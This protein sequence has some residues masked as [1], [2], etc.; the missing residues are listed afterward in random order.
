MVV[1][2]CARTPEASGRTCRTRSNQRR[3]IKMWSSAGAQRRRSG[4]PR[5]QAPAEL[6]DGKEGQ[7]GEPVPHPATVADWVPF[8][9]ARSY[10]RWL[11]AHGIDYL[12]LEE[13]GELER[14]LR[15]EWLHRKGGEVD[16]LR[17]EWLRR[18]NRSPGS[19]RGE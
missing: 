7:V 14:R 9:L 19:T 11:R 12:D 18:E 6:A 8:E 10:D 2:A 13:G 3:P 16:R 4:N 5:A 17:S 1:L 15:A